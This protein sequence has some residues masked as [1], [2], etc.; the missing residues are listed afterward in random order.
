MF[1]SSSIFGS[2]LVVFD[3]ENA[4]VI[5]SD[6]FNSESEELIKTFKSFEAAEEFCDEYSQDI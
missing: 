1:F 3:G 4:Y 6:E 5:P 2:S